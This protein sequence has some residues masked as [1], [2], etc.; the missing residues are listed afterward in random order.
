MGKTAAISNN[1]I[2]VNQVIEALE[3][4]IQSHDAGLTCSDSLVID[5]VRNEKLKAVMI[6]VMEVQV[7]AVEVLGG[8]HVPVPNG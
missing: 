4:E 2:S 1:S 6:G 5:K 8:A 7:S 3:T